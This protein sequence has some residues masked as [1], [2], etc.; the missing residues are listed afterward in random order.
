MIKRIISAFSFALTVALLL[1]SCGIQIGSFSFGGEY[2][3]TP[4]EAIEK[5]EIT[6]YVAGKDGY[7][8]IREDGSVY[9]INDDYSI[10]FAI[11]DYSRNNSII[12]TVLSVVLM[13]TDN[14]K[15]HYMGSYTDY[16][17]EILRCTSDSK[18]KEV[19]GVFTAEGEEIN[20]CFG[21]KEFFDRASREEKYV[22]YDGEV[23]LDGEI[24]EITVAVPK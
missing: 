20:Y 7:R 18:E 23:K 14:G 5:E 15:Y 4:K 24:Y 19:S 12:E 8:E 3:S 13:K 1:T 21:K 6:N 22:F 17:T 10:Y 9:K 2:Y 16:S 11:V